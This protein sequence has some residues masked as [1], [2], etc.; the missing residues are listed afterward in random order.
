[1]WRIFRLIAGTIGVLALVVFVY[2]AASV[3]GAIFPG[4]ANS[5]R[6]PG[7]DE[8]IYLLTTLLHADFA[9]PVDDAVRERFAYLVA[10]GIPIANPGLQYLVFGWG[11]KAFYTTARTL[12]DIRP[13][14]T[15]TAVTGDKSVVRLVPAGD[16]SQ[17]ENAYAVDLPAGGTERLLDFIEQSIAGSRNNHE[18]LPGKGF[19]TGDIFFE[20]N[21][22]F[23]IFR[24][25]NIWA[26]DGLRVAGLNTGRWTPT[27]H[28]L[29]L[30]L[31]IHS[32]QAVR[33]PIVWE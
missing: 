23:H 28:S 9:I 31:R 18:I 20:A 33:D 11:S 16:I 5:G 32:P 19:G 25:C 14:P 12:S 21:G 22:G 6:S 4:N 15:F 3:A 10:D 26:A 8:R 7:N 27:T 30:G 2:L 24:P 13:G 17:L 1:M 29:L